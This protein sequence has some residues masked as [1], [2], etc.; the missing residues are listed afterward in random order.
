M[1]SFHNRQEAE[2]RERELVLAQRTAQLEERSLQ[3]ESFS[4]S[5]SHDLRSPLRAIN[6]FA[7][8][9][10]QRH[11]VG[12]NEEGRHSIDNILDASA[13]MGRL[14]EDLL[15]YTRLGRSAITL[16]P[17]ALSEIL[18]PVIRNLEP[19]ALE[20]GVSLE[21][22]DDLPF[23]MGDRTLLSQVFANLLDN[24]ITYRRPDRASVIELKWKEEGKN[25][26]VSVTDNGIGIDAAHFEKIFE[27]FQRLHPQEQ[28]P[29]TGIG[30]AIV[31]TA[32]QLLRGAVRVES[33]LGSGTTFH[34][35]L[36]WAAATESVL[37]FASTT[38]V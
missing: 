29:G 27:V 18:T 38:R 10:S 36:E 28:Y 26:V 32:T 30:L 5:V 17:V 3:L 16:K 13:H 21:V 8:I 34:V 11:R 1:R 37:P 6:G 12:L 23:V 4:Y 20:L 33:T 31:M 15:S 22:A 25:V 7:Q 35:T 19:R 24:A 9:L 14:I 2:A